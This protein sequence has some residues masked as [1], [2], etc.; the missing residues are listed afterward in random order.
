MPI[1]PYNNVINQRQTPALY[2]DTLANQ[3]A[4]G[5]TGRLFV[6]QD[7]FALYRDNGTGWDLI[8]G[9]GT[10]TITGSGTTGKIPKFTGST[11]IGDSVISESAGVITVAGNVVAPR[12]GITGAPHSYITSAGAFSLDLKIS[13]DDNMSFFTGNG[14]TNQ[15]SFVDG[16]GLQLMLTAEAP[17]WKTTGGLVSQ[18]VTGTGSLVTFP[19]NVSAFV[20]DAGYLT[21][22][23]GASSIAGTANQV[24]VNGATAP[25]TGAVTLSLPQSIATTSSPTFS[26]VTATVNLIAQNQVIA[27]SVVAARDGSNTAGSGAYLELQNAAATKIWLT[28]LNASNGTDWWYSNDGLVYN[29]QMSLSTAGVLTLATWNG[30]V[31]GS[32]YGGAG[33][34]NGILKANGAGTV[35]A[36]TPGTDYV[37]SNVYTADGTLTGNRTISASTFTLSYSGTNATEILYTIANTYNS[38]GSS[39]FARLNLSA[40]NG[41]CISSIISDPAG[42]GV[43][44]KGGLVMG[45]TTAHALVLFTNNTLAVDITTAQIVN[46]ASRVNING[47]ADNSNFQLNVAGCIYTNSFSPTAS[48]KTTNWTIGDNTTYIFTGGAGVTATFENPAITNKLIIIKNYSANTLTIAS[49]NGTTNGIVNLTNTV[50]ASVSLLTGQVAIFQQS[51]GTHTFQLM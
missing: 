3:P 2:T 30:A 7:T 32:S 28:Q 11:V 29:K 51:G 25:Q 23:T 19:T 18:Y 43:G 34:V 37:T 41:S 17:A 15:G 24:L 35:S 33:T 31:I 12:Y 13:A 39:R 48:T 8:G 26:T 16:V 6:S 4:A 44:A 5:L 21:A 42:F 38:G 14:L 10:G 46:F 1:T 9:P 20:N 22:A 50:V 36:A 40:N 27:L 45:T 47:A 49:Y